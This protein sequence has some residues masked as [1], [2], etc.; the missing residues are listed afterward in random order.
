MSLPLQLSLLIAGCA[1]LIS[2]TWVDAYPVE[3]E[4]FSMSIAF[5]V[6]GSVIGLVRSS[7]AK[8]Y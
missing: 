1:F 8:S 6:L 2:W 3:G 5:L 7:S 4:L